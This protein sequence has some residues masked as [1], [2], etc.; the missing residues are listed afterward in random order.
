MFVD[1][2]IELDQMLRKAREEREAR[3]DP[4]GMVKARIATVAAQEEQEKKV[5]YQTI[6]I[7]KN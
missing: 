1:R 3:N 2:I 4:T 7:Q 5:I 6:M